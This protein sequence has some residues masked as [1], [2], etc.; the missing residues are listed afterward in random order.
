MQDNT[1]K[2]V[3]PQNSMEI[4]GVITQDMNEAEYLLKIEKYYGFSCIVRV[5]SFNPA[6]FHSTNR[7]KE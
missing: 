1:I 5:M 6:N 7:G 4:I 2:V 3:T